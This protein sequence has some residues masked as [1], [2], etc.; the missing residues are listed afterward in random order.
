MFLNSLPVISLSRLLL[1]FLKYICINSGTPIKKIKDTDAYWFKM[2]KQKFRI[3]TE[4]FHEIL[5]ICPR[6]PNQDFVEP[7]SEE[8]MVPFIRKLGYTSKCDMVSEIHTDHMHQPWRTFAAVIIWCISGKSIGNS[9]ISLARKENMP[10]PRFI[11]VI[12]NHFISKDK[13][14]STINQPIKDSKECKFYLAYA[15]GVATPKEA[16]K[17]KKPASPSKKQTLVLEDEPAKKSKRAKHP[18][19]A[20]NSTPAKEDVSSKKPSRKKSAGVVI[21][22]TLGVSVLKKKA[23]AKVDRRKDVDFLSDVAIL[24]AAQLKKVHDELQDKIIGINEGTGTI[25][26]VP[27]V[28]KD[29]SKSENESWGESGDDDDSDD[30]EVTQDDE[31]LPTPD[32]YI[33]TNDEINYKSKNVD[34]EEYEKINEELYGDVNVNLTD[35]DPDD[36]DK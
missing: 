30:D 8:E 23:P 1:K 21:R 5:Q 24:K 32:D 13:T 10:Y 3:K 9:D 29:Q 15:T 7:P 27:Y 14:I 26:G 35:V 11:K 4:V 22:D 19:H 12:S 31:F 6:L 20:K 2:D 25:P 33:P 36:K 28:P 18:Q 16:R 34:E 17:F